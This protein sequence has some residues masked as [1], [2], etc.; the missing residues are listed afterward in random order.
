MKIA[1]SDDHLLYID[2]EAYVRRHLLP[3]SFTCRYCDSE[4]VVD[5]IG[6]F[7]ATSVQHQ[8]KLGVKCMVCGEEGHLPESSTSFS[9]KAKQHYDAIAK[10]YTR[11]Y[12]RF[13]VA[14]KEDSDDL[15]LVWFLLIVTF[16]AA[17][18]IFAMSGW[19]NIPG[20]IATVDGG[21]LA[22]AIW[23][24]NFPRHRFPK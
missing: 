3:V 17:L 13:Y 9:E 22:M 14:V 5:F 8:W 12:N 18:M 16:V 2:P 6:D 1:R 11:D 23:A 19:H 10:F 24:L 7:Y 20:V 21:L 15:E 4:L